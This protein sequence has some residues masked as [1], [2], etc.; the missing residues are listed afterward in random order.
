MRKIISAM[1][2]SMIF[3]L[4]SFLAVAQPK[5][6]IIGGDIYDWKD[7]NAA[8]G[9]LK[10]DVKIK[11]EGNEQL[12]IEE[13]KPACGCTTAPLDKNILAPGEVAT[14]SVTLNI[15]AYSGN[16]SKTV[17]LKSNDP[18]KPLRHLELRA[19]I[20][21]SIIFK[22]STYMPFRD[23]QVGKESVSV[24]YMKNNSTEKFTISDIEIYPEDAPLKINLTGKITLEPSQEVEVI[25]RMTPKEA[26]YQN[27]KIVMKTTNPDFPVVSIPAYGT[28]A[29]SPYLNNEK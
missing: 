23:L 27:A 24:I 9:P 26:G 1:V 19:N 3:G 20:I 29:A 2:I 28:A 7:V 13:V 17:G 25:G 15:S 8:Q 12:K 21:R 14:L 10:A 4:C 22:P 18:E 11:N 5:L 16:V 6:T